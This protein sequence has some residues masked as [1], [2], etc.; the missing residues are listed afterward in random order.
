MAQVAAVLLDVGGVF[1]LPNPELV[2][3]ALAPFGVTAAAEACDRAHYAG[4]AALTE[5]DEGDLDVWRAYQRA[6]VGML[7]VGDEHREA[8]VDALLDAFVRGEMWTRVVPGSREALAE[9]AA[10]GFEL[11]IVSN[12]T[13]TVEQRL[14][15]H[16]I[17]QIGP[18]PGVAVRAIVDSAVVGHA[19]PDPRIFD[20]ALDAL[21][22]GPEDVV[23]I[24]DTPGADVDGARAAGIEPILV[25]PYDDHPGFDGIRVGSL[26]E[27]G[28]LL[29]GSGRATS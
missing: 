29:T 7:G 13:G 15:D 8:A 1:H 17:C 18:G 10:L 24:G 25:D 5:F 3:E 14:L 23:H 20:F 26:A 27:V 12:S 22:V 9:L 11:A 19:K 6:Y 2:N 4:V 28:Q 16:A 21:G